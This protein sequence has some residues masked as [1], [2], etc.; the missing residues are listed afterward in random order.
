MPASEY[1]SE[2]DFSDAEAQDRTAGVVDDAVQQAVMQYGYDDELFQAWRDRRR[3]TAKGLA[4][5]GRWW[6]WLWTFARGGERSKSGA[7]ASTRRSGSPATPAP[8]IAAAVAAA[9][10]LAA[11]FERWASGALWHTGDRTGR[12]ATGTHRRAR[13][14]GRA[15]APSSAAPADFRAHGLQRRSVGARRRAASGEG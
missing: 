5:G 7:G 6:L 11:L 15:R 2:F 12:G 13:R 14:A 10:T 4:G 1:D 3:D 9:P 8:L